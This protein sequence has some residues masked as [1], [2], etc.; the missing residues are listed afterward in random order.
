MTLQ[1]KQYK[2]IISK[3]AAEQHL[4]YEVVDKTYKSFW[5]F[6]RTK[7]SALPL[8]SELSEE[9]FNQLRTSIN[10]PSIG[11]FHCSYDRY[12]K[13]KQRYNYI[14]YLQDDNQKD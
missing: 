6:V 4:P 12:K 14:K 8:K 10:I 3:V 7:L 2:E 11:K 9:Q 13:V 5:L 1:E